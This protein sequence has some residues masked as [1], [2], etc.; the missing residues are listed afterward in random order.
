MGQQLTTCVEGL[1]ASSV[2][3][4]HAALPSTNEVA[5][6]W[7]NIMSTRSGGLG[8]DV[9][10]LGAAAAASGLSRTGTKKYWVVCRG[11][12]DCTLTY[13]ATQQGGAATAKGIIHLLKADVKAKNTGD[14]EA[15]QVSSLTRTCA[16]ILLGICG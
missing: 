16:G 13:Y 8:I 11:W 9:P 3:I 15:L 7:L 6:G 10:S 14:E 1:T 12:P 5:A 4:E 2:D